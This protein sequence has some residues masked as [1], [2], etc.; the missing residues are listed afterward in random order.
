[1]AVVAG[2][3][4]TLYWQRA[5]SRKPAAGSPPVI[6][7][8]PADDRPRQILLLT[9]H[10]AQHPQDAPARFRLAEL[11]FKLNDYDRSLA[12]LRALE[13]SR[14][15]DAHVYLRRAVVLKYAGETDAAEKAIRRALALRP[16]DELTR[17]WL[18]EIYLDQARY[19][20]ALALFDRCLQRQPDSYFALLG[21]GRALEQLL[22]SRHPIPLPQALQPVQKAVRL[23][24]DHPE[25]LAT[26]ARMTF[27]YEQRPDEAERL[28]LRAAALDPQGARPYIILAQIALSRPP[29]PENLRKAGEYAYEAGRRDLRDPR[30]PY[31]V[32]RVFLQ[33]NEIDRAV[34]ALER[35]IA[36]GPMPE[37]V[38][39]LAVAHR[40]AG[41]VAQ[42]QHF[43]DLY[44]RYTDLLGRRNALLAARERAPRDVRHDYALAEL[45]LEASQP[46]TAAYWL[47]AAKKLQPR[48][49][50]CD[51]LMAQVRK[52][53]A[54]GSRAPMLPIP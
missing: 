35:S 46:D 14:P 5:S 16:H 10:L 4:N 7:R 20:E 30:P 18:G 6:R 50:R 52:R 22:L 2:V 3:T 43:A 51:R 31:F 28:A 53:R 25:G 23:N 36:L 8:P 11:Y 12:E 29:A 41:K 24:P 48:D 45:Y 15:K 54:E 49:P 34:Q 17:E 26:L 32:G 39:Y 33:Q 9:E 21:K 38:S 37:A 42:A 13:R 27:T 44:Q 1:L 19:H 47:E 40:R